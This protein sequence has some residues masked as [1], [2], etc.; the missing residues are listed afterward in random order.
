VQQLSEVDTPAESSGARPY[1]TLTVGVVAESAPGEKRV[2]LAPEAVAKLIKA[3]MAVVVE[4]GAGVAAE[5]DDAA[6]EAVGA[7]VVDGATAWSSDIVCKIRP[8]A[9]G[10]ETNKLSKDQILF[11]N[12]YPRQNEKLV[13][14]SAPLCRCTVYVTFL[15]P[16]I[17][18]NG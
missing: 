6:Y 11:S 5:F 2:A 18:K 10:M 9:V 7:K 12:I 3:G 13:E 8:P 17:I 1:D 14:V 15:L 4:R 16:T